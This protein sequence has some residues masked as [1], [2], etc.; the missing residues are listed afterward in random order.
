MKQ[1]TQGWCRATKILTQDNGYTQTTQEE[2]R[3][4][5]KSFLN[6]HFLSKN[7]PD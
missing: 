5:T 6:N 3:N 4:K 1:S 7:F 2:N